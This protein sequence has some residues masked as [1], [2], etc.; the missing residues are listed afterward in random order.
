MLRL[1]TLILCM[2]GVTPQPDVASP[3]PASGI[4]LREQPG[5]LI[6]N[7]KTHTQKV[8]DRLDP[9][10]VVR[11]HYTLSA[12]QTTW[13][14]ARWTREVLA[15]AQ[16][17][18][19]HMLHQLQK[20]TVTQAELSGYNRRP[21]RFLGA[22][23]GAAAAVGT[24]FNIGMNTANAVNLATVRR[25]VGEIQAEI[26]QQL[27]VQSHALRTFGKSLNGTVTILNTHSTLLNQTIKS[28]NKLFS[29][30]Q[31]DLAQTQLLTTLMTDMLREV[32]SSIDNL[33]MG[34]IPHYLIPLSLV[35][36]ILTSATAG[37][38]SPI[39]THL[40]FSLGSAIPLYVDPEAG[41]LAFLLSLPIIDSN[42]IYRLKDVVN[43]GFWQGNTCVKI[44]TP[45]VVAY[46]DNNEQ[47]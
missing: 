31:N 37:P 25:H 11:A 13:A 42:N 47:L 2:I 10:N 14:G 19:N 36:N 5:L 30:V 9:C 38:A 27:L 29:V 28:I 12:A 6:T 33:A 40:A 39:Q 8:F 41:D 43:V 17:D 16:A 4:V 22:L 18:V 32:S 34:R 24:L 35:Q 21:K 15:H 46:H 7:C 20:I 44:H 26:R 3:G 23:L 45:E 1:A